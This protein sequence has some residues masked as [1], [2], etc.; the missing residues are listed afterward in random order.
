MCGIISFGKTAPWQI[1]KKEGP[2]LVAMASCKSIG[3][4]KSVYAKI[5]KPEVVARIVYFTNMLRL[6]SGNKDYSCGLL[7]NMPQSDN[8]YIKLTTLASNLYMDESDKQ[9]DM[10]GLAY[11]HMSRNLAQALKVCPKYLAAFIR[12]G[13]IAMPN[14]HDPYPGW[15]THVCKRNPGRFIKAFQTL[16]PKARHYISHYIIQPKGCKQI[17][18]QEAP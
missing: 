9:I 11:W 2:S 13:Q 12:Y 3:C 15:V 14:M 1:P 6:Q 5:E 16:S 10:V 18:V 4:I 17:A 8:G 7:T